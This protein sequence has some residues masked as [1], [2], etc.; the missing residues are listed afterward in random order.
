MK[1]VVVFA[2]A[3]AAL[4]SVPAGAAELPLKADP[5]FNWT[6]WYL[7]VNTG[8]SWGRNRITINNTAVI[9]TESVQ[10]R[11]WLASGEGGYC[12][13]IPNG[14]TV[15]CIELRYDF[16]R[17][18]SRRI[19]IDIPPGT[20]SGNDDHID[21]FLIGPHFGFLTDRNRTMWYLAGGL[22]VGQVGGNSTA[23]GPGGTTTASASSWKAGGFVGIGVE[24]MVDQH[25]SWKIE[26]DYVR[27]ASGKGATSLY[28]S[29]QLRDLPAGSTASFG[30]NAYDNVIIV[31]LNYHFGTH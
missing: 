25:W 18:R 6:G 31:G 29:T 20:S 24:R 16:P 28:S 21:P 7:G 3:F 11:G 22:A 13:Q 14:A 12:W 10:H 27:F 2:A 26:Y 23:T 5:L 4:F 1:K 19:T 30:G 9:I 15:T 8:Y 17:E